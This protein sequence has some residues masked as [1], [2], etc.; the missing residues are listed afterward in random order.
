[1]DEQ[2]ANYISLK[3]IMLRCYAKSPT[4]QTSSHSLPACLASPISTIAG[5]TPAQGQHALRAR[6][7]VTCH[8]LKLNCEMA[9]NVVKGSPN[10]S[11]LPR[12]N[13]RSSNKRQPSPQWRSYRSGRTYHS[14]SG[15]YTSYPVNY[16]KQLLKEN[17]TSTFHHT[18]GSQS[19]N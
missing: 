4:E 5:R 6:W 19:Q 18:F 3:K 7:Q 13:F 8:M 15:S 17:L 12:N 16:S 9:T 11:S 14:S 1:M 10:R 2:S